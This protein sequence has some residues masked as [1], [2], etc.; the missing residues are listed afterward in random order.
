MDLN[1]FKRVNDLQGHA[2]GDRV[3]RE[4]SLGAF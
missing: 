2:L 4:S 3:L 1:N